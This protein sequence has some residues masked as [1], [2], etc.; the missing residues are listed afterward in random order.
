MKRTILS[1]GSDDYSTLFSHRILR[2][3]DKYLKLAAGEIVYPVMAAI[4]PTYGCE[5]NCLGCEYRKVNRKGLVALDFAVYEKFIRS[6]ASHG[7]LAVDFSGGG[8]PM[9]HPKIVDMLNL[10]HSLGLKIGVLTSGAWFDDEVTHTLARTASYVRFSLDSATPKTFEKVR[11][12][13]V[14]F[15]FEHVIKNIKDLLT[16]RHKVG[17]SLPVEVSI[18]FLVNRVNK[19]E[20]RKFL[21]LGKTLG[22]DR[23]VYK[24]LRAS[25][26]S[27]A[28]RELKKIEQELK[29]YIARF[30]YPF[31]TGVWLAH[32][33]VPK[34]CVVN[35]LVAVVDANADMYL[36][37]YYLH[38]QKEHWIGNLKQ[39]S[40]EEIWDSEYHLKKR[41]QIDWRKCKIFDCHLAQYQLYLEGIEKSNAKEVLA[42]L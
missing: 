11:R 29:A 16:I 40:F 37:A 1:T 6:F 32:R 25:K 33:G 22:V 34:H 14:D 27:L 28:E 42:F 26:Y 17:R 30:N 35:S 10:A 3:Y 20:I 7:G 9:L 38:R 4:H 2:H 24:S 5:L 21:K 23:V 12:P 31:S 41:A 19:D 36:C 39:K 15:K 18:K 13:K 8:M